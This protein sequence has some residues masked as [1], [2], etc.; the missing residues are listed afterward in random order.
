VA[1]AAT[2]PLVLVIGL[3]AKN[4]HLTGQFATSTWLG[5]SLAKLTTFHLPADARQTL[6]AQGA[7]SPVALVDPFSAPERYPTLLASIRPTG[8]VALDRRR[9]TG[10]AVNFNHLVYPL[11]SRHYLDDATTVIRRRPGVYVDALATAGLMYFRPSADYPL[12]EPGRSRI[13]PWVRGYNAVV[14]G[15]P[16]FPTT[17]SFELQGADTVGWFIVGG[18]LVC[19]AA[20]GRACWN[21]LRQ[22]MP[23]PSSAL[24]AFLWLNVVYVTLL[25]NAVEIDENQRFRF[26][27]NPLLTVMLAAVAT[28][29]VQRV[30]RLPRIRARSGHCR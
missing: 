14:A 1:L 23:A 30:R 10:G 8:V 24:L 6:V 18:F 21:V 7:L 19:L 11:V 27:I 15:Q 9:K 22:P 3:Y 2:L 12:L 4:A 28:A 16:R 13:E 20:G 29:A 17:T 25:G 26:L 5:M